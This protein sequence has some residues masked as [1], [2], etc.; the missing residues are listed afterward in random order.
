[1]GQADR[2][3]QRGALELV[4]YAAGD[5]G[6]A[7]V[8]PAAGSVTIGRGE[9]NDVRIDDAS[10]SRRHAVL[11]VGPVL[12]IEDKGSANGTFV[13]TS[14]DKGSAVETRRV[15]RAPGET[16]D[17]ELGDCIVLG[18][19]IAVVRRA[20]HE[21]GP[22]AAE[23]ARR[24]GAGRMIVEDPGM[25]ALHEEARRA[26]GSPF[27]VLL[28]GETGVGKEILARAIHEAS[29][30]RAK[31]FVAVHCA[32][33][34]ETLLE[35]ELFGHKKG[36]FTGATEDKKGLFEAADGGT[37]LLDEIGELSPSVQVKLLRVLEDRAVLRIGAVAPKPVDVRFIAATNRDLEAEALRG[38]F[39]QDLFYRLNGITF[40]VPP[41]R[42][43]KAEL[44]KLAAF[45]LEDAWKKLERK[46]TP[47]IAKEAR[48]LLEQHAFPGNVRELKNAME[49]AAV[50]CAGDTVLP[51]HLPPRIAR[52]SGPPPA[53]AGAPA[54]VV[55]TATQPISEVDVHEAQKRL[56]ERQRI[57]DALEKCAHNQTR[58]AEMLGISRRTLVSRLEEYDLPRPRKR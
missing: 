33:L 53:Q 32:A 21:E 17:V 5:E 11:H 23:E 18:S 50:L 39:R 22:K 19:V 27:N 9:G 49:R 36:S 8:L 46:G 31:P 6:A 47:S 54:T 38:A 43:R 42:E 37:V 56:D 10:V 2:E 1:M 52:S 25:R 13:R 45:F 14:E 26:A 57:L 41:L 28:L 30:R 7:T 4:V 51:E 15:H 48:E 16:F 58:A 3:E 20:R 44:G 12:R 29:P 35:S 55:S 40:V 24:G 34:S